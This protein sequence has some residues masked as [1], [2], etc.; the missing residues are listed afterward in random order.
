MQGHYQQQPQGHYQQQPQGHYQQQPQGQENNKTQ[1]AT[2]ETKS[3]HQVKTHGGKAAFEF[4][5]DET[6][7][8]WSTI[9]LEGAAKINDNTKR[10]AW[11]N[12][13]TIQITKVE[14]PIVAAVLLGFMPSCEFG[15]H[16]ETNKGFALIN[17][18][19]KF[20]FKIYEPGNNKR[21]YVCPVPL[22]E[23]NLMGTLALSQHTKNFPLLS[24]D[25][26]LTAI[27]SLASQMIKNGAAPLAKEMPQRN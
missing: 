20:F 26:A 6:K 9:R 8:G 7:D 4:S 14:L 23:A 19:N 21:M 22:V 1:Q 10:Y 11:Q 15:N 17:Q 27:R 2:E 12:K 16:G 18:G 13:I 5:P 3:Y 25:S 24:S